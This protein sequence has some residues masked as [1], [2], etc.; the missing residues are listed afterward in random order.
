VHACGDETAAHSAYGA[1][2]IAA[3]VCGA[4]DFV[5]AH[6][7]GGASVAPNPTRASAWSDI[8]Q[9]HDA[10]RARQATTRQR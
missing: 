6:I 4:P 5:V 8:A 9:R 7:A 2:V 10:A 3:T 1:A